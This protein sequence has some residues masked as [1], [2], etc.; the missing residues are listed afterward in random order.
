MAEENEIQT[1]TVQSCA[2][3]PFVTPVP[4]C[5]ESE[6]VEIDPETMDDDVPALCPMMDGN[7]RASGDKWVRLAPWILS[8]QPDDIDD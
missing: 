5:S 3:C 6:T 7:A 4:M 2:E 1:I 8:Q